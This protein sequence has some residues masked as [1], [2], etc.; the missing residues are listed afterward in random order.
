MLLSVFIEAT[1]KGKNMLPNGGEHILSF[2]SS[3]FFNV[4]AKS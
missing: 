1:L 4:E 2:N 3:P